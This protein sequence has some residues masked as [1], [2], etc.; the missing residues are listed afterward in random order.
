MSHIREKQN[1]KTTFVDFD[2]F[3]DANEKITLRDLE[4]LLKGNR[5]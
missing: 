4:L 3:K 1:V 5:F 2:I